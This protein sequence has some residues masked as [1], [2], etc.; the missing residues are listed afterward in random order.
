MTGSRPF[1]RVSTLPLRLEDEIPQSV[2]YIMGMKL[3]GGFLDGQTVHFSRNLNCIIGGRGAGKSTTFEAIRCLSPS[4]SFSKLIDSEIWPETL[5]VVWVDKA[6]Q[7]HTIRRRIGEDME[8]LSDAEL[9]TTFQLE[10][11]GQNETAQTSVKAQDDPGALL[12]YMDQ[13]VDLASL[14]NTD[15]ELRAALLDNQS[16]IEKAHT[17][18]ARIP[19]YK[20]LLANTQQ[21][22]KVLETANA[23]EM[24]ALERRIAEERKLREDLDRQ[25]LGLGAHIKKH[26]VATLVSAIETATKP[27]ALKVGSAEFKRI[28]ELAAQ[29]LSVIRPAETQV[30]RDADEFTKNVRHQLDQWKAQEQQVLTTI[31]QKRKELL[32]NGIKLDLAYIKKLATDEAVYR[33]ALKTLATWE[34]VLK[35]YQKTRIELLGK[36]QRV[37][38]QIFTCRNSYA[39][40]ANGALK[41]AL[42]DLS[43]SVKFV[44]G[45]LSPEAEQIIQQAANWRT[46]QVPKA[47]SVVEQVTVPRLLDAVRKSDPAPL[48][49]VKSS[50]GIKAFGTT[51]ANELLQVLAQ[52][53]TLFRLQRCEVDDLPRVRVTKRVEQ[54][55]KTQF[56]SRDF[57][58]LSLGQQ[59]SI[60]LALMLSSDSDAPLI[61]DN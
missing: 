60:L 7:Q 57:S 10:C 5:H 21:Q 38:S 37:R 49:Q 26:S 36:R 31:D 47:A 17:Q 61:G 25:I 59:Q 40:K 50:D 2:A 13:F 53:T 3:E 44:E 15:E 27:E 34:G 45:A 46:S 41:T 22:L 51:E 12:K 14:Q 18:V 1:T 48:L 55:G 20:K 52:P 6:G 9:G 58:K 4:P 8:N 32:A 11:Y 42:S 43:V 24:V 29:F 33:E 23:Q 35:E 39:V 19:D 16:E 56:V 28:A 30:T 54:G